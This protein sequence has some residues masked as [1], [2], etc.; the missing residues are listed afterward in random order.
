MKTKRE[1]PLILVA[2]DELLYA[3]IYQNKLVMEGYEVVMVGN[4]KEAIRVAQD[5]QPDL[6]LLDMIMPEIDGFQVLAGLKSDPSTRD[7]KIIVLSNLSQPSDLETAKNLGAMEYLVKSNLSIS[8]LIKK[9]KTYLTSS[10]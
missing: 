3:K 6:I 5:S 7:I 10:T 2:E 8:D 9:I 1:K 4:G